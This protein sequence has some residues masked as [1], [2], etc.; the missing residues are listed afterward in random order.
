MSGRIMILKVVFGALGWLIGV[1]IVGIYADLS[2]QGRMPALGNL[3]GLA[4]GY[5][6]WRLAAAIKSR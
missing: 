6:G 2:G 3:L 5:G 4:L 1:A